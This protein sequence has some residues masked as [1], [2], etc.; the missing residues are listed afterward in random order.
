MKRIAIL[1]A[2][3]CVVLAAAGCGDSDTGC[4][5]DCAGKKCGPDGCGGDCSPG[6]GAG[7]TC[8]ADGLCECT[9][10][11]A[12]KCCGDDRCGEACP[13]TCVPGEVCDPDTCT[14]VPDC[15]PT[16]HLCDDGLCH[17]C[18]GNDHCQPDEICNADHTCVFPPHTRVLVLDEQGGTPIVNAG[19][20]IHATP[21]DLTASTD[22]DGVADFDGIEP[23]IGN[24]ASI[25]A[26]HPA[27]HYVTVVNVE[28][29]DIIVYLTRLHNLSTAG[30]FRDEFDFSRI[31]C[32]PGDSC[33]VNVGLAGASLSGN[34]F[35]MN[36]DMLLGEQVMVHIELGGT[37]EDLLMPAGLALGLNQTWFK[38]FFSP[39]AAPGARVAWG[40]GGKINLV[41]MIEVLGPYISGGDVDQ[42]R[43]MVQVLD[44]CQGNYTAIVPGVEIAPIPK[45]ID[46]DD[47]NG[48]G[49]TTD[50]VADYDNFPPLPGGP[51]VLEVP[52]DR[53]MIFSV[54]PLPAG[55]GGYIYDSV[56]I[57]AG[58]LVRGAG[59]VPLGAGAGLDVV[60][61]DD[62]PDGVVEDIVVT[63]AEVAG[64]LPEDQVRR[65]V[66]AL[67]MDTTTGD[68][69]WRSLAGQVLFVDEFSGTHI[70]PPFRA[71][72]TV[73]YDPL[74]RRASIADLPAG[75]DYLHMIFD[76]PANSTWQVLAPPAEGA[77]DLP[78][79]PPFGDR[80]DAMTL[81][82]V[83]L[84]NGVSYQDLP[85]FNDTNMNILIE[86]VTAFAITT[87]S[88]SIMNS[89]CDDC[90]TTTGSASTLALLG[91]LLG[92]AVLRSYRR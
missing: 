40:L 55:A 81:V 88:D 4:E 39:T 72:A 62:L 75:T 48:N 85:A 44:M 38:E 57:L 63:V 86:L 9:P 24:P 54:A 22:I 76:G 13:N 77:F 19:V 69:G 41:D 26:S 84:A 8:G 20:T 36:L 5:P 37:S 67:A 89:S 10:N 50:L 7:E 66:L 47:I 61:A 60:S 83:E 73:T 25:S 11:C 6:C 53:T 82:A 87:Q 51:M 59:L 65:V 45:V 52:R 16:F 46:V 30:G 56:F 43:L 70:L 21:N 17:E 2:A 12:G 35:N 42:A 27:Y 78:A 58:V 33:E 79:A 91:M 15:G 28:S 18:C 23:D 80:A 90:A 32:E 92:L 49:D 14:C 3:L 64:R 1:T 68:I 29:N 71:P 34:L 31:V 74:D